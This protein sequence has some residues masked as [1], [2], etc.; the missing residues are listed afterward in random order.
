[1]N[2][3]FQRGSMRHLWVDYAK[4]IGIVLVVYGH[5]ARGLMAS[6]VPM[7]T[8]LYSTIDSIVYS[9]HMPLF[10]FLSGVFFVDSLEKRGGRRF[11]LNKV[12]V[13]LYPYVVWSILQGSVEVVL[14]GWTNNHINLSDLFSLFWMP[15]AQF[16]FLYALFGISLVSMVLYG[17]VK[18]SYVLLGFGFVLYLLGVTYL[19]GSPLLYISAFCVYFLSGV[20]FAKEIGPERL[21]GRLWPL[22]GLCLFVS[23]Q[24]VFYLKP[25]WFFGNFLSYFVLAE[26]SILFV[27]S[28][29]IWLSRWDMKIL[30]SIGAASM[31]IYVMHVLSGSGARVLLLAVLG[32]NDFYMH[33]FLGCL[34]GLLIP[35]LI[36][37]FSSRFGA[38]LSNPFSFENRFG[39][40]FA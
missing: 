30:A 9:F 37:R 35:Y 25:E 34:S 18:N 24:V 32:I 39:M 12:D 27:V 2:N 11:F 29:C 13:V 38:L 14:S 8:A 28:L 33:L 15:R 31:A 21:S 17:F 20:F 1:M 19:A 40:R 6:G 26:V 16:W 4:A 5:V 3:D 36:F 7:D 10:F 22:L 23:A